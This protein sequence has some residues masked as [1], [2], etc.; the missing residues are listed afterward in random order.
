MLLHLNHLQQTDCFDQF[1]VSLSCIFQIYISSAA[2]ICHSP[3]QRHVEASS[4]NPLVFWRPWLVCL[5]FELD[6][7]IPLPCRHDLL[8]HFSACKSC[9]IVPNRLCLYLLGGVPLILLCWSNDALAVHLS[10]QFRECSYQKVINNVF[11]TFTLN[12]NWLSVPPIDF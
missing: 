5:H 9:W 7:H 2:W 11:K 1:F 3:W 10:S 6:F 8:P 4:S 12:F